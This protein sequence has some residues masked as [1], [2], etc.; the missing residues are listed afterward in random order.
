RIGDPGADPYYD[1]IVSATPG[2]FRDQVRYLRDHFRLIGVPELLPIAEDGFRVAGPTALITFDD[3]YRD[4]LDLALPVLREFGAP[5][6]LFVATGFLLR[7]RLPWWAHVAYVVKASRRERLAIEAPEPL[8]VDLTHGDRREAMMAVIGV[9]LRA[10]SPDDP[11]LLAHL[12]E[13]AGVE[14][15]AEALGRE[16][17]LSWDQVRQL[18]GAGVGIGSH[19]QDHPLLARLSEDAQRRELV[20]S[21]RTLE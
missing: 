2:A 15:D 6:L 1:P 5:A 12:A 20:E 11:T 13:R 21:R 10:Q 19:T 14:V 9:Y 8:E 17:F 16:L 7:P 3:G 18:A 4:N